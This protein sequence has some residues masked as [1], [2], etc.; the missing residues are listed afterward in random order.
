MNKKVLRKR[1]LLIALTI[2]YLLLLLL[3]FGGYAFFYGV[4]LLVPLFLLADNIM[5][6]RI[7]RHIEKSEPPISE[8]YQFSFAVSFVPCLLL[9]L[10]SISILF[11]PM[12]GYIM[13]YILYISA[14]AVPVIPFL[15]FWQLLYLINKSRY[16][17]NTE[18]KSI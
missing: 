13:L 8:R 16:T 4:I 5:T 14:I 15:I 6:K 10:Y 1:L 9:L 18:E 17:T 2:F 7:K 11:D 12:R 3:G